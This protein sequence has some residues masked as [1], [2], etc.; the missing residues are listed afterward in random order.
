MCKEIGGKTNL[1]LEPPPEGH[2][3]TAEPTSEEY[4]VLITNKYLNAS[5][6][7]NESLLQYLLDVNVP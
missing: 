1:T 6:P 5:H 4:C 2:T 3:A 7:S